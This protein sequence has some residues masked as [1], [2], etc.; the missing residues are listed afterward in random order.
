MRKLIYSI[1]LTA[2][3]LS[4]CGGSGEETLESKKIDT[5][6]VQG[7]IEA[8][9]VS[10]GTTNLHNNDGE[11]EVPNVKISDQC[12]LT[13]VPTQKT[14]EDE[15]NLIQSNATSF[16]GTLKEIEKKDGAV[17]YHEKS[18]FMEKV[19]EGY[20]FLV[21]IKG[22]GKNY[23]IKG[24]GENPFAPITSKEDAEKAFK[25]AQTFKPE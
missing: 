18:E 5:K 1:A 2:I 13:I 12:R 6:D 8:G 15:W 9:D 22:E 3:I 24:E 19:T 17:I 25:I 10:I 7:T 16:D 20:N 23:V 4:S 11:F 21:M 14:F